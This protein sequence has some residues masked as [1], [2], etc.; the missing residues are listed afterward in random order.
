MAIDLGRRS[1]SIDFIRPDFPYTGLCQTFRR[2][3]ARY[4]LIQRYPR[5]ERGDHRHRP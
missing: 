3:M 1:A 2:E 5:R 4:G